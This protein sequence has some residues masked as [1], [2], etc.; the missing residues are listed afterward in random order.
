MRHH[1]LQIDPKYQEVIHT[2]TIITQITIPVVIWIPTQR[3][4]VGLHRR[5][6]SWGSNIHTIRQEAWEQ[7]MSKGIIPYH[8]IFQG[9]G[10]T[11]L[12]LRVS[13]IDL[14]ICLAELNQQTTW[15]QVMVA[16]PTHRPTLAWPPSPVASPAIPWAGAGPVAFLIR[17]LIQIQEIC[18]WLDTQ[19]K[20]CER[21]EM[22][23]SSL[24]TEWRPWPRGKQ[25]AILNQLI[26]IP[27]I[28]LGPTEDFLRIKAWIL[29]QTALIGLTIT[30]DLSTQLGHHWSHRWCLQHKVSK[31]RSIAPTWMHWIHQPYQ[32]AG[33]IKV[34]HHQAQTIDELLSQI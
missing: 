30:G 21:P 23:S 22:V 27:T 9:I 34:P 16:D 2:A 29:R 13:M 15:L 32:Q 1:R 3:A 8:T 17:P 26:E 19:N 31:I 12:R 33:E 25:R 20:M 10:S 18:G 7:R 14:I 24:R 11:I 28:M 4:L 5:I 6:T